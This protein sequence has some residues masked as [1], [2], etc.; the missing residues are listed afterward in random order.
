[1]L[2]L[3]E[4]KEWEWLAGGESST[5]IDLAKVV[6]STWLS[7]GSNYII[8]LLRHLHTR[9]WERNSMKNQRLTL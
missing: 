4:K 7:T 9:M 1:M 3:G 8:A 5:I 2:G 6:L